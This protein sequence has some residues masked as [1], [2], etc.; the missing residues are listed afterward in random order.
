MAK[1]NATVDD[2]FREF[3]EEELAVIQKEVSLAPCGSDRLE[4]NFSSLKFYSEARS[5]RISLQLMEAV[6]MFRET[7]NSVLKKIIVDLMQK[8]NK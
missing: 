1:L 8:T 7:D 4:S 2:E 6:L 5:A 3:S